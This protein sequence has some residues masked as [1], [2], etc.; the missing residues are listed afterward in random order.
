MPISQS[1]L[2]VIGKKNENQ[3]LVVLQCEK[4]EFVGQTLIEREAI[5]WWYL[6]PD[7]NVFS[8]EEFIDVFID[9]KS[10]YPRTPFVPKPPVKAKWKQV[11]SNLSSKST[12]STK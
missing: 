6:L 3:D 5:D 12:K 2:L 9:N 8:Q 4:A 1:E 10:R 11:I 7:S